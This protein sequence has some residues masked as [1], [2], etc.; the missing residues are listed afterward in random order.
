[1]S[2]A[3]LSAASAAK[4]IDVAIVGGGIAGLS[5]AQ[6]LAG[7]HRVRLFE[8]EALLAAHASGRNAAIFRPLELDATSAALTRESLRVLG[9]L[10]DPLPLRPSGLV[11]CAATRAALQPLAEVAARDAV[12][13]EWLEGAALTARLPVLERGE[14]RHALW[15]PGGGVLDI[16][17]VTSALASAARRAGAELSTGS[18]VASIEVRDGRVQ[19]LCLHDG[20][21]LACGAV[22]LAAGAWSA[23]LGAAIGAP[24]PLQPLRRHLVQL[25]V[26]A[27][28]GAEHPV[29]WRV[30]DELYFRPETGGVLASPCDATALDPQGEPPVER[31]EL[32]RLA[33][34]LA[35]TAPS[36]A[37]GTVRSHWACL[38]TFAPDRE[39]VVGADP[40]VQGLHWL[41]G[42]GGRGMG[43]AIG[44]ARALA[45]ALADPSQV[46]A[47]ATWGRANP[48]NP[49]R[50]LG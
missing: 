22:V 38:R 30:D 25:T 29:V 41:G 39:L 2:A 27:P 18:T 50:F 32:E 5:V 3:N 28:L 46:E 9:E 35:R 10:L 43:V 16:H 11:L 36:L 6:A 15:V 37:E 17:A 8:R 7:T 47:N 1:V 48:M 42:L 26:R 21:R 12:Q 13:A 31:A 4:D 23:T 45:R 44:A 40:R 20:T 34:K 19:G 33:D 49:A 14:V 24:L